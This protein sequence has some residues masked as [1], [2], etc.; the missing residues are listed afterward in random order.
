VEDF[1]N[2]SDKPSSGERRPLETNRILNSGAVL[3][4]KNEGDRLD[5]LDPRCHLS[6]AGALCDPFPIFLVSDAQGVEKD[7]EHRARKQYA[8]SE[9]THHVLDTTESAQFRSQPSLNS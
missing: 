2:R 9:S 5:G 6:R 7:R 3:V 8:T 1:W 4:R